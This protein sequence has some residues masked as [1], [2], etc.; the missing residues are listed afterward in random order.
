M[1]LEEICLAPQLGLNQ[2]FFDDFSKVVDLNLKG[3]V[4]P[5]M[6]FSESMSKTG[7]GN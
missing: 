6:V 4:L 2:T 7:S 3:T 1:W 5:T